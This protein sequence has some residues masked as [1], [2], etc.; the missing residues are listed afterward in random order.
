[1]RQRKRFL[2]VYGIVYFLIVVIMVGGLKVWSKSKFSPDKLENMIAGKPRLIAQISNLCKVQLLGDPKVGKEYVKFSF[3]CNDGSKAISTLALSAFPD[4][5]VSG[6]VDEY[7]RIVNFE[8]KISTSVRWRCKFNGEELNLESGKKM[9]EPATT[10]ECYQS[11]EAG[12]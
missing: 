8:D 12:R 4:R 1:M 7:A 2:I 10:I 11:M 5:S 3:S 6:V 9:I